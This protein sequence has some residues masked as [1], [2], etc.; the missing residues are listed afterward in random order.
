MELIWAKQVT[1]V[2]GKD[3]PVE[4]SCWKIYES[5]ILLAYVVNM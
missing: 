3:T 5:V 4:G 1:N 2:E